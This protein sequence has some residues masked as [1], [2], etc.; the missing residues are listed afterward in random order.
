MP[1]ASDALPLEPAWRGWIRAVLAWL[2]ERMFEIEPGA[3][4]I[5]V[6]GRAVFLLLLALWGLHLL[7]LPI[8]GRDGGEGLGGSFMHLINL[9]FHEAG[10]T[11]FS[12]FGSFLHVLGGTLGQ[13]LV[14]LVIL[15]AFL[16]RRDPFGAGV[17]LWWLGESLIDCAPYIFDARAGQLMLL[18]GVTGQEM[19]GYHDWE[20]ILG[21][22]G[23]LSYDHAIARGAWLLGLLCMGAAVAWGGYVLWR[24]WVCAGY[25]EDEKGRGLED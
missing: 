18:G 21:G 12:M 17:G 23:W 13:L 9:P 1:E 24:Q 8:D 11:V 2:R 10:H 7:R 14:P 4:R 22:L 16:Q 19:P 25:G 20:V 3:S 15:G 5:A 6:V